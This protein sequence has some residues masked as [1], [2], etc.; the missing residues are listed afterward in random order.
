[1]MIIHAG[2]IWRL[3]AFCHEYRI[4]A[5]IRIQVD[6]FLNKAKRKS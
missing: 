2:A 5:Q 1:M 4:I 3:R 6:E